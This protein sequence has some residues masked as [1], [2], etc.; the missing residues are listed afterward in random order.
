MEY[1]K[2]SSEQITY[3][4]LILVSMQSNQDERWRETERVKESRRAH[5]VILRGG[6]L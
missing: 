2:L 3:Y 6:L 4:D 5:E 1:A